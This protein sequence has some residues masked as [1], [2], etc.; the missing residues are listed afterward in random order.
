MPILEKNN[1]YQRLA[2]I[3]NRIKENME[4]VESS[5]FIIEDVTDIFYS[6]L[7]R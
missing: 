6:P 3:H 7:T 1:N 2:A 5:M 4:K